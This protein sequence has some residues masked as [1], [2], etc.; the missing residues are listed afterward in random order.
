MNLLQLSNCRWHRGTDLLQRFVGE[1]VVAVHRFAVVGCVLRATS[2]PSSRL[3]VE[4]K[5]SIHTTHL[6]FR[7][8]CSTDVHQTTHEVFL[9]TRGDSAYTAQRH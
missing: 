7:D 8:D 9:H 5:R 1:N 4:A 3:Q 2:A 6:C